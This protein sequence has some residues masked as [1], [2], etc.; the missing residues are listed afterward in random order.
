[1][2][3][4]SSRF[5]KLYTATRVILGSAIT[6]LLATSSFAGFNQYSIGLK[7]GAD[8]VNSTI[9][10]TDLVGLPAV[11]QLNWNNI[12][13]AAGNFP[14]LTADNSGVAVI[15]S[16]GV[17][18]NGPNTWASGGNSANFLPD[19]P[20]TNLVHGYLD[21]ATGGTTLVTITNLPA[22]LTTAGYDVYIYAVGDT[23]GRG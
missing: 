10:P 14:G 20:N 5:T 13:G 3:T 19:S 16:V 12:S 11:A 7:F 6:L 8:Q 21:T 23:G 17:T 9:Q 1:M 15:T 22:E 4:P 2:N 18:W